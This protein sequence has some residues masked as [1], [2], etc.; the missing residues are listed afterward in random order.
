MADGRFLLSGDSSSGSKILRANS[1]G[2]LDTFFGTG[3]VQTVNFG[4]TSTNIIDLAIDQA[5]RIVLG[6]YLAGANNT[7]DFAVA[8]LNPN[9]SFDTSFQFGRHGVRKFPRQL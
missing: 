1:D 5:G 9:G 4:S 3:G 7:S 2:A 8:R 6:G